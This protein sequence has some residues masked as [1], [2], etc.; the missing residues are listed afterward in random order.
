MTAGLDA[1]QL[2]RQTRKMPNQRVCSACLAVGSAGPDSAPAG[3]HQHQ[4]QVSCGA[5]STDARKLTYAP[6]P[7]RDPSPLSLLPFLTVSL[8]V[9]STLSRGPV[10][11]A[12]TRRALQLPQLFQHR[13][14]D[15]L[16]VP[17]HVL[18]HHLHE[19]RRKTADV[20]WRQVHVDCALL[21]DS[22]LALPRRGIS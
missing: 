22:R 1:P 12:R 13:H 15:A 19:Q 14:L 7:D 21:I 5:P 2:S 18:V 17:P 20:L 6:D 16:H 8:A 11:M 3:R 9:A 10:C 4:R